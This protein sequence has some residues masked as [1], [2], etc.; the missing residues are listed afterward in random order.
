MQWL[1]PNSAC[2]ERNIFRDHPSLLGQPLNESL[3]K[4]DR[5]LCWWQE[6]S[7]WI[8]RINT[9]QGMA[10]SC[11]SGESL[12]LEE[13]YGPVLSSRLAIWSLAPDVCPSL[14]IRRD[15]T[16][17]WGIWSTHKVLSTGNRLRVCVLHM[18]VFRHFPVTDAQFAR[19]AS[20][21][22][23]S[24]RNG[25]SG[26]CDRP[27]I[28]CQSLCVQEQQVT[29]SLCTLDTIVFFSFGTAAHKACAARNP[30][31]KQRPKPST[32]CATV[33]WFQSTQTV[34]FRGSVNGRLWRLIH[35]GY[36]FRGK[37]YS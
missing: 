15:C 30:T 31:H 27:A 4:K 18:R 32:V 25:F 37:F 33:S 19:Q 17:R 29:Y 2:W 10:G 13:H 16:I 11:P 26:P 35:G 9:F 28:A 5:I 36:L 3:A 34:W 22:W 12:R 7:F 1:N 6:D 8:L 24:S 14:C 20:V 23:R 21:Q